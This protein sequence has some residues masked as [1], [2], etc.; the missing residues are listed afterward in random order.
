MK[1]YCDN[2]AEILQRSNRYRKIRNVVGFITIATLLV[3][4][5][6]FIVNLIVTACGRSF[7]DP[8]VTAYSVNVVITLI[9]LVAMAAL[10]E[11]EGARSSHCK[12]Y[13]DSAKLCLVTRDFEETLSIFPGEQSIFLD[14][15]NYEYRLYDVEQTLKFA[16]LYDYQPPQYPLTKWQ[17]VLAN[18]ANLDTK[19]SKAE[20][21]ACFKLKFAIS[22][23]ALTDE[24]RHILML[25]LEN[26]KT[27]KESLTPW[28]IA[29]F[30]IKESGNLEIAQ[31][32][33]N[34]NPYGFRQ[35]SVE[36]VE[37][38]HPTSY[39]LEIV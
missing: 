18:L 12:I 3:T 33:L 30:T 1:I 15:L 7:K 10:A 26:I 22:P 8:V 32:F 17:R 31:T 37:V 23:Q 28:I 34:N 2:S 29:G 20:Y 36:L 27:L 21:R 11:S 13:I 35:V 19:R 25:D 38:S 39:D 24:G 9:C 16:F 14:N 5:V 6:G 4:I